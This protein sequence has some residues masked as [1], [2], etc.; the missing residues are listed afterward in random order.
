MVVESL[1]KISGR[2]AVFLHWSQD[3]KIH[4]SDERYIEALEDVFDFVIVVRN[5]NRLTSEKV[6]IL[7]V[8][9]K[10]I[11][12]MRSNLG[13]DFGGYKAGIAFLSEYKNELKEILICNN[14]VFLIKDSLEKTMSIVRSEMTPIVAATSSLEINSHV[15]SFFI[16]FKSLVLAD[17]RFWSYW[18]TANTFQDKEMTVRE[19]EIP[20]KSN[21]EKLGYEAT[22]IW[23]YERLLRFAQSPA[24]FALYQENTRDLR[25]QNLYT[26][27]NSGNGFNV[28]HRMWKQL[29]ELDFPFV[30]KDLKRVLGNIYGLKNIEA[31]CDTKVIYKSIYTESKN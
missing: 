20:L 27:I 16:H 21:F 26:L 11:E 24:G 4:K 6:E 19:L 8:S 10:R 3:E 17:E 30:K 13:Y 31:Y 29:L 28:T 7:S 23:S 25:W 15:Q 22:A 12:L 1:P 18:N 2:V 9:Q 14:S 5:Q